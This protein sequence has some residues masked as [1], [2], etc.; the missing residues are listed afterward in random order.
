M[1]AEHGSRGWRRACRFFRKG[2]VVL[3]GEGLCPRE[4]QLRMN[5]TGLAV[6]R[7][8]KEPGERVDFQP[9]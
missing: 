3:S 4:E 9:G 6:P 7:N 5:V 2:S 8:R 1:D